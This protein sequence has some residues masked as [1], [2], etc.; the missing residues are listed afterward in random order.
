VAINFEI[1]STVVGSTIVG[2]SEQGTYTNVCTAKA[3]FGTKGFWHN[4]NGLDEIDD[5]DIAYV[6]SLAPYATE[7]DYFDDGDEP[8]DGQFTDGTLVEAAQGSWGDTVAPEGSPKA[9]ISRFLVDTNAGADPRE[10]LAQQLL[11]FIFNTRNYLG[12]TDVAVELPDGTFATAGELIDAAIAAWES[13][14]A[15]EQHE[16]Q[17]LLD[18]FNNNDAVEFVPATPCAL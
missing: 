4:K 11:A 17:A 14:T 15:D 2:S 5:S 8:F 1:T 9:E 3:D 13:G 16:L 18:G 12:S 6:N 10:Q 7:S